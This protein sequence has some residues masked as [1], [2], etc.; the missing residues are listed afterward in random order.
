MNAVDENGLELPT[1][2]TE[3]HFAARESLPE[4]LRSAFDLLVGEYKFL[5]SIHHRMPFVSYVVLA[6]LI[7]RGW[8]PPPI[9]AETANLTD[10]S[11]KE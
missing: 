4:N 1:K 9:E 6:D 8:C 2:K 3:K 10:E 5:A 11:R 7:R